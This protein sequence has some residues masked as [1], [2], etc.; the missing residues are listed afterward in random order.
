M[1][2][3]VDV[4]LLPPLKS[5]VTA[6]LGLLSRTP[7]SV[8]Y[9]RSK[10]LRRRINQRA[11]EMEF[12]MVI[13]FSSSMAQFIPSR[14]DIF[15]V[16]DFTD[17]DSDKW[18]QYAE[19]ASFPHNCVYRLEG[20]RLQRYER[21]VMSLVD[22]CTVISP[23]EE[24]LLRSRSQ[25]AMIHTVPN[26]VD[27]EYYKSNSPY[28]AAQTGDQPRL[29]F[30]G[31]MD[32]YANVNGILYFEDQILH[33]I[34]KEI[35]QVKFTIVGGNPAPAIRRLGRSDHITVTGYVEDVRPFLRQ[36]SVCVVPLRIARG[37]QNK[38]LEAMAMGL[39]VVTTTR[40]VEGIDA[41][42]G[43]HVIV[44]DDPGEFAARTVELLLDGDL[45][46]RLSRQAR[47]F[48][49]TKYSWSSCLQRLDDIL[50]TVVMKQKKVSA[51][52]RPLPRSGEEFPEQ[53]A[54]DH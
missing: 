10:E 50:E 3:F 40:A 26:G 11:R 39:P 18:F 31:V 35:P 49:E 19:H 14:P 20:K 1:C 9:F 45:R 7:L 6:L 51:A 28:D 15:R 32:Y 42:P 23:Q 25:S 12:D 2:D 4:V 48:V 47:E 36:A 21:A 38:I 33:R 13:A 27:L 22:G 34:Q 8:L 16:M 30:T 41:H 24:R 53:T 5:K 46:T 17:V 44:A 54:G 52:F 43:K 29:V 37:V